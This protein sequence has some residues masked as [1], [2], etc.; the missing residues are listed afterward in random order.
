MEL[1]RQIGRRI[2]TTSKVEP[3]SREGRKP[4]PYSTTTAPHFHGVCQ[5]RGRVSRIYVFKFNSPGYEI[6]SPPQDIHAVQHAFTT[7]AQAY[8]NLGKQRPSAISP[9]FNNNICRSQCPHRYHPVVGDANIGM[10]IDRRLLLAT[11]ENPRDGNHTTIRDIT[12][13]PTVPYRAPRWLPSIP[14]SLL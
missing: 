8:C 4:R 9:Y 11:N 14:R 3:C 1:G 12:V 5:L 2:S 10:E 13:I 6:G 7:R